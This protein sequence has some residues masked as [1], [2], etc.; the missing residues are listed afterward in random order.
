MGARSPLGRA[1]THSATSDNG[2]PDPGSAVR[3]QV[4]AST[5]A[6]I[7]AETPGAELRAEGVVL[8]K[9]SRHVTDDGIDIEVDGDKE[10]FLILAADFGKAA[11]HLRRTF[12]A[13]VD[14]KKGDDTRI[15]LSRSLARRDGR[16]LHTCP[17]KCIQV[18]LSI[19]TRISLPVRIERVLTSRALAKPTGIKRRSNVWPRPS[20][21]TW[22]RFE[23]PWAM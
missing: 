16:V 12:P 22:S 19:S 14:K 10:S 13:V 8:L 21:I 11:E 1:N 23:T 18:L 6:A 4:G 17:P 2:G 20:Q 7:L 15:A 5:G 9:A 3:N